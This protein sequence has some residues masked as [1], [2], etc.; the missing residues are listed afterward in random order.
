LTFLKKYKPY[1]LEW[2]EYIDQPPM[3]GGTTTSK[4]K[5]KNGN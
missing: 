2:R 4:R 1:A 5:M 3:D